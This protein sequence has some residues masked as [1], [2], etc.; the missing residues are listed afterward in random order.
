MPLL[1]FVRQ[2]I[3]DRVSLAV[4][5]HRLW[6]LLSEDSKLYWEWCYFSRLRAHR[7]VALV[8]GPPWRF[9]EPL[10][11]ASSPRYCW[12][13]TLD[14]GEHSH[15]PLQFTP[16]AYHNRCCFV[17]LNLM[18]SITCWRLIVY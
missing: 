1:S 15:P 3:A 17:K 6:L 4:V 14:V 2:L 7:L 8:A 9:K 16:K 18:L 5:S 11:L 13:R 10:G 12:V